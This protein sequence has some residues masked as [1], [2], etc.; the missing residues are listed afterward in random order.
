MVLVAA[1]APWNQWVTVIVTKYVPA[2]AR[3]NCH[4]TGC[5]AAERKEALQTGSNSRPV[6]KPKEAVYMQTTNI[7]IHPYTAI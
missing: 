5:T 6:F 3:C 1:M 7:K 2:A 4:N